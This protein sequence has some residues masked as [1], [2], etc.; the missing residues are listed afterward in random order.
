MKSFWFHFELV[1][2]INNQCRLTG[3]TTPT[4]AGGHISRGAKKHAPCQVCE[5]KIYFNLNKFIEAEQ[6]KILGLNHFHSETVNYII[7][8]MEHVSTVFI[9]WMSKEVEFNNSSGYS[10]AF[11]GEFRPPLS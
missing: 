10:D 5:T 7:F 3:V 2:C 8:L 9:G 6:N 11:I 4:S 1:S